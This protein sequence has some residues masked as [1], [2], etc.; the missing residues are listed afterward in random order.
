MRLAKAF[1][2]GRAESEICA[3]SFYAELATCFPS[4]PHDSAV[5]QKAV[6]HQKEQ[7]H[8]LILFDP[9]EAQRT[10]NAPSTA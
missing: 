8:D 9:D 2:D 1:S 10:L 5:E 6:S 4:N 7:S 3:D